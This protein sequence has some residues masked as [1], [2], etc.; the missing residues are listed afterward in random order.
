ME[1]RVIDIRLR[2]VW[3]PA[4]HLLVH[5]L[6][7]D[8]LLGLHGS[9]S[10]MQTSASAQVGGVL[11]DATRGLSHPGGGPSGVFGDGIDNG[12]GVAGHAIGVGGVFGNEVELQSNSSGVS[13]SYLNLLLAGDPIPY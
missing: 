3:W 6:H 12:G 11:G 10:S 8:P 9:A 5:L 13:G 2:E 1:R 7:Q 4:L